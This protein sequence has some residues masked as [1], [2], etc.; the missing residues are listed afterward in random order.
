MVYLKDGQRFQ[1]VLDFLSGC[2]ILYPHQLTTTQNTQKTY[3]K[4]PPNDD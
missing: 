2:D 4:N 3:E 1:Y